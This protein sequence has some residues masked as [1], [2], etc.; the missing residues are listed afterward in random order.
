MR[1]KIIIFLE[2]LEKNTIQIVENNVTIEVNNDM[3]QSRGTITVI[4]NIGQ[5]RVAEN[6][7]ITEMTEETGESYE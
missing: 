7:P 2:K 1:R 5:L 6:E 4:E 3:C